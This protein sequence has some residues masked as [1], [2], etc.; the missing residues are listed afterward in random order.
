VRQTLDDAGT[1]RATTS[2]DPWGTPQ[3]TLSAPFGFTGELHHQG[4]VYLRA[5]WYAPG[6]G[7]FTSRDPFAGFPEMPYSLHAYQYAYSNPVRY[8]DP[9]GL[10]CVEVNSNYTFGTTCQHNPILGDFNDLAPVR[11]VGGFV[12]KGVEVGRGIGTP[13]T[14]EGRATLWRGLQAAANEPPAQS[15]N[16][17][18]N[19]SSEQWSLTT[20][21]AQSLWNAPLCTIGLL[22]AEDWGAITFDIAS[23]IVGTRGVIRGARSRTL[24]TTSKPVL[25]PR[26]TYT[27][28]ANVYL[29]EQGPY[30]FEARLGSDGILKLNVKTKINGVYGDIRAAEE[31]REAVNHFG[32]GRIQAIRGVWDEMAEGLGDNLKKFNELTQSGLYSP[33]GAALETWTGQVAAQAGYN[34]VSIVYLDP[35]SSSGPYR[36]VIVEFL[37]R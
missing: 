13:F 12:G 24:R 36:L 34:Q 28:Q 1:V 16:V 10:F 26:I 3:D 15:W 9:S 14:A 37:K 35:P 27:R 11:F 22:S 6:Q 29:A 2:Y 17:I 4:Q 18:H 20:L 33:E 30:Y 23:T 8:V 32:H 25:S 31:F 19:Y 5:R 7:T 21:G